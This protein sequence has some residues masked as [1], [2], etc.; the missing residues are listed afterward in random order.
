L[1]DESTFN[2]TPT[3]T[4]L[5]SE[6]LVLSMLSFYALVSLACA[7]F[8]VAQSN[9]TTLDIEAIE[10]HFKQSGITPGLFSSFNPVGVL[11][12]EF[13]GVNGDIAPGQPL[14]KD[15]ESKMSCFTGIIDVHDFSQRSRPPRNLRSSEPMPAKPSL[16]HIQLLW[17][18]PVLLAPTTLKVSRGIGW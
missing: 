17:S 11:S 4:L 10:A 14:T 6:I 7:S 3:C 1:L 9:S 18:T 15:R 5:R 2:T 16:R 12:V 8:A 13:D